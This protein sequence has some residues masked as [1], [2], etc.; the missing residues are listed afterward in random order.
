MSHSEEI[1]APQMPA[2]MREVSETEFFAMLKADSRDI[3]P[4]ITAPNF[5][6]WETNHRQVW[7]WTTPGWKN[8]GTPKRYAV[9]RS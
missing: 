8:S 6:S 1:S 5:T 4:R 9:V 3:M 7:G 2:D